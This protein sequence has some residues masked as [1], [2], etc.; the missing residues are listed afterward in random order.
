ML[1]VVVVGRV[2]GA[3]SRC[4]LTVSDSE[5]PHSWWWK[6]GFSGVVQLQGRSEAVPS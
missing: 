6:F 1:L 3:W 2:G 5:S 4:H